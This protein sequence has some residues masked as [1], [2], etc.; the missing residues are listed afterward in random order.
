VIPA[1]DKVLF[2]YDTRLRYIVGDVNGTYN[3]IGQTRD[4]MSAKFLSP[5]SDYSIQEKTTAAYL[6]YDL[7]TEVFGHRLKAN[8]GLRYYRTELTSDGSINVGGALQ[9]VSVPHTYSG[10]LPALMWLLRTARSRGPVQR[11]PRHQPAGPVRPGGRR[12]YFDSPIWRQSQHRQSNLKPFKADSVEGSLEYYDG[13]VGFVSIGTFYKKMDAFISSTTTV[14]PY[15]ATGYPLS[16]LLPGQ[17]G[18][19]LY[20]VSQPV[21]VSGANIKGVELAVQRDFNFLPWPFNHLV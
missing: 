9:R 12:H 15:S 8:T 17:T 18:S 3:L 21:N 20:N 2:P 7:N 19:I 13:Q 6:Q 5:G 1:S 11:Q 16:F 14:E 4:I 10:V